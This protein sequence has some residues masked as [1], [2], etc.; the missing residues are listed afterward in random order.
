MFVMTTYI[1]SE[2]APWPL[3]GR[4]FAGTDCPPSWQ[5]GFRDVGIGCVAF[6]DWQRINAARGRNRRDRAVFEILSEL[7]LEGYLH[8]NVGDDRFGRSYGL[9]LLIPE[10]EL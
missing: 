5:S 1:T 6:T 3:L 10:G 4:S 2:A 8:P 7:E 9:F